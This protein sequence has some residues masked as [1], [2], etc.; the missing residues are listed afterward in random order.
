MKK[1][2]IK[3]LGVWQTDRLHSQIKYRFKRA[4]KKKING[5]EIQRVWNSYIEE[6]I[7]EDL[8]VGSIVKLDSN[9][10]IWVKAIP[11]TEHKQ[12]M[13]LLK[14]GLMLKG[15][16]IV[17]ANINFDTSKYIY[18]IV[19]ENK[20]MNKDYKLYFKPHPKLSEAVNEGV[21]K[22]KLIIRF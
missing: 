17:A 6:E 21:T 1:T 22:G 5:Q 14:Q 8:K 12:A 18:K 10:K 7:I 15:G 9:S 19:Y 20:K 2:P 11:I 13:S 16:M 4:Y 3:R